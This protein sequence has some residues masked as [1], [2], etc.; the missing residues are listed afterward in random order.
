V[1]QP[2]LQ[3][4]AC[5]I[6]CDIRVARKLGCITAKIGSVLCHP[7]QYQYSSAILVYII[8]AVQDHQY[9]AS[10]CRFFPNSPE[11]KYQ[12]KIYCMH[13][14]KYTMSPILAISTT[15]LSLVCRAGMPQHSVSCWCLPSQLLSFILRSSQASMLLV[16]SFSSCWTIA[17]MSCITH[18]RVS[19]HILASS[20]YTYPQHPVDMS[21]C[22]SQD[23]MLAEIFH[24]PPP[25]PYLTHHLSRCCKYCSKMHNV[26]TSRGVLLITTRVPQRVLRRGSQA[27]YLWRY[28]GSPQGT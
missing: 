14:H 15:T 25:P 10:Q 5:E 23:A 7:T 18:N 26:D 11:F 12:V 6:I 1:L 20:F 2:R 13:S 28:P 4:V 16:I 22:L 9:P 3:R 17:P 21:T 8:A 19:M 27:Q 24:M